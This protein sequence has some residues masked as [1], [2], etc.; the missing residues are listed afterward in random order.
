MKKIIVCLLIIIAFATL[1]FRCASE[2]LKYFPV[3]YCL[4]ACA[5]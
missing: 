2:C 5:E 3:D 1:A 4:K